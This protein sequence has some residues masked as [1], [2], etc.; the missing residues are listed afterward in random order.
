MIEL[1]HWYGR[2]GNN[3]QQCAIGTMIARNQRSTFKSIDHE[4]IF[5]HTTSFGSSDEKQVSK[6]FY[7]EG[8][9]KEVDVETSQVYEEMREICKDFVRPHLDVPKVTVPDD[10]VVIHIRSGDVFDKHVE[11][12]IHYVR[13]PMRY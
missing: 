1:S 9:Y 6:F 2:L 12:P 13:T 3:I 10:T 7:Y 8:K 5:P 11:N 4:I